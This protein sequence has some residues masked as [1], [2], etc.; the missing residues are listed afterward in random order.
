MLGNPSE[1]L[2]AALLLLF[3]CWTTALAS[4]KGM[5][6]WKVPA[7]KEWQEDQHEFEASRKGYKNECLLSC[8]PVDP[9]T[10]GTW[11]GKQLLWGIVFT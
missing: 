4:G 11:K 1:K 9:K 8:G 6:K 2:S 10:V 5:L 7:K 3:A